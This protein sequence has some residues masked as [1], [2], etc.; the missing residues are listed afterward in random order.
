LF[1]QADQE[2]KKDVK[3]ALN[4]EENFVSYPINGRILSGSH[5][6]IDKTL[7]ICGAKYPMSGYTDVPVFPL[8]GTQTSLQEQCL[9]QWT[10][11]VFAALY[12][13]NIQSDEIIYLVMGI[14]LLV[15]MSDQVPQ[16]IK[17]VYKKLCKVMLKKKRLN[18]VDLTE[19]EFLE[20]GNLPVP[21]SGRIAEFFHFMDSV[22]AKLNI[23]AKP[24]KLWY[25][26]CR[27]IGGKLFSAQEQHS[28]T[29]SEYSEDFLIQGL[30]IGFDQIPSEMTYDYK[31]IVTLDD[32]SQ[33]GGYRIL[34]HK[35]ISNYICSPVYLLSEQGKETLCRS[36]NCI[37]PVCF[38][39]LKRLSGFAPVGPMVPF[40]LP[41]SY[42][43]QYF[44]ANVSNDQPKHAQGQAKG[45]VTPGTGTAGTIVVLRGS[46]GGGKST[47]AHAAKQHV[48][49]RGG[50][51]LIASTDFYCK[52]GLQM[53][54]AVLRV[55]QSL[56][57]FL[58]DDHKD[59]VAIIDTC[60][61]RWNNK[62]TVFFNVDFAKWKQVVVYPN[63]QKDRGQFVNLD[64][65][66]SWSL[67]NV[68]LRHSPSPSDNHWLNPMDTSEQLCKDVHK[69]KSTALFGGKAWKLS[70][71]TISNLGP[72]ADAY[73]KTLQP[74]QFDF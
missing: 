36:G 37:C 62:L 6:L 1:Q 60:G 23:V 63:L 73:A 20:Q 11:A 42:K 22:S 2:L 72:H 13:T 68:L 71:G 18:T 65:Y 55:E 54:V 74:F 57:D 49:A 4:I 50:R 27:A 5:R 29:H 59:K 25:E 12:K 28:L 17:E 45:L 35:N 24:M 16:N 61:E 70:G 64:G 40:D 31:C 10:R 39:P 9:R 15:S 30:V 52:Q 66:L 51:C 33:C 26:M 38:T 3:N 8:D 53:N 48:E 46:V 44:S 56:R 34:P 41:E 14:N 19:L 43:N 32:L 47:Y 69:K 67:R 7:T 21:N 58:N